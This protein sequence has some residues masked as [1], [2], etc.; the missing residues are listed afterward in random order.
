M[1]SAENPPQ[2]AAAGPAQVL[3]LT[4]AVGI[5]VGIVVGAGIFKTPS[6]VAANAASEGMLLAVWVAGGFVSLIGALC[7]AEL[8]TAYPHTGGDYHY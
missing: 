5:I 8:A 4:D 7:Y 2:T 6:I 1:P 3:S